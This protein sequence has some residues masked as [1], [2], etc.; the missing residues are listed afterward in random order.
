MHVRSDFLPFVTLCVALLGAGCGSNLTLTVHP[1]TPAAVELVPSPQ[2]REQAYKKILL[3]PPESAVQV[4]KVESKIV[5]AKDAGYYTSLLE[6]SLLGQ[7][8]EVI[9]AE[10]TARA[11]AAAAGK[12]AMEK[13]IMLGKQTKAD[14]VLLLQN[15]AA[16]GA[17]RYF[18]ISAMPATEVEVARVKFDEDDGTPWHAETEACLYRLPFYE[19]RVEAKLID[20]RSGTVLWVGSGR[21]TS[22]D[23]IKESWVADMDDNCEV[24]G[25]NFIY[26]AYIDSEDTLQKT[27][28]TLIQRLIEPL[29]KDAFSGK[30]IVDELPP[31]PPPPPPPVV[32]AAPVKKMAVVSAKGSLREGADNKSKKMMVVPR[33]TKVEIVETMGEWHKVKVQDGTQGWMHESTL[34]L[35]E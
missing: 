23:V 26:A 4:E 33:K 21:Q 7:G 25:Q 9:S 2:L 10:V 19:L 16:H 30:A 17:A 15:V 22:T 1:T 27:A 18:D 11:G 12:N 29:K 31:P 28:T 6:K 20:T 8:F 5:Q 34:I 14:A 13:A 24:K 32:E 3:L 35:E